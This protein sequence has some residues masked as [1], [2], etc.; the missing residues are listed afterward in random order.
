MKLKPNWG[1]KVATTLP[2]AQWIQRTINYDPHT[3]V[4]WKHYGPQPLP[5]WQ[6]VAWVIYVVAILTVV[7]TVGGM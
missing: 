2:E 7:L 6:K 3:N 5:R 1:G 4:P